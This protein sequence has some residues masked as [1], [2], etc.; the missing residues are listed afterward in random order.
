MDG[1][2]ATFGGDYS[3]RVF[4][5]NVELKQQIID[6]HA[7][8]GVYRHVRAEEAR[9]GKK[10]WGR[11]S[12]VDVILGARYFGTQTT[13]K[14]TTHRTGD[15]HQTE[16]DLSRWD[17]FFGARGNYSFAS[18]WVVNLIA[19]I[20][21]FGIGNAAQFTYN[22]DAN[23]AF[24]ISHPLTAFVGYRVLGYNMADDA[25]DQTDITQYGPKIGVALTF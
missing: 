25:D 9:P 6:I 23:V 24:R 22:V 8:Y 17:P 11:V 12:A 20:G 1:T 15:V 4:D 14:E 5:L 10:A 3:G 13:L 2:W 18:R 16:V 19:D 21:G 7:G